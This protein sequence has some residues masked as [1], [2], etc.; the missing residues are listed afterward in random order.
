[1][2]L[3]AFLISWRKRARDW[4]RTHLRRKREGFNTW[5]NSF[6]QERESLRDFMKVTLSVAR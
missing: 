6:W 4:S 3:T 1:M 5:T 2:K